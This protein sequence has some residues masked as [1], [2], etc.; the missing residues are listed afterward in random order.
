MTEDTIV[1][2][3][4]QMKQVIINL[5]LDKGDSASDGKGDI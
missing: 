3:K 1:A 4:A 2:D 5:E